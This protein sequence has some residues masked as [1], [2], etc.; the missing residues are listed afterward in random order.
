[1]QEEIKIKLENFEGPM[2]LLLSLVKEKK[3]DI[4]DI[5][6][7]ELASQ[8]LV[9]INKIKDED[10]NL[11][12]DYLVMAST[13]LHLKTKILI[14]NPQQVEEV[15]EEKKDLLKQLLQYQQY[16]KLA[17][18]LRD[19]EIRRR[20]IYIKKH[21]NY[22]AFIK[23]TDETLLHGKSDAVK[24]IIQ[25]RKMFERVNAQKFRTS[26]IESFNMSPAERR[27]ELLQLFKKNPKPKFEE[28][29][30][31]PTINHFAITLLTILDMSRRQE[32]IIKQEEQFGDITIVKGEINE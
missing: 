11:A 19:K 17:I 21:S 14:D 31:V 30:G 3:V 2:D 16:K 15:E 25:L 5:D 6:V 23:P 28:I 13:M 9:I 32:V 27:L 18:E 26:T 29:F 24:L 4:F 20:E 1:M 22:N 10:V 12:A 8:Y 7:S